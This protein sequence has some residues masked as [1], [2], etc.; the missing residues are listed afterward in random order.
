MRG[1][2]CLLVAGISG[3]TSGAGGMLVAG[4][5]PPVL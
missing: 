2:G 1:G 3:L 4:W 5:V